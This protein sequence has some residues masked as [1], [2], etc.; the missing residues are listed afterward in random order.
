MVT[1]YDDVVDAGAAAKHSGDEESVLASL[2]PIPEVLNKPEELTPEEWTIIRQQWKRCLYRGIRSR[3]R[4]G[5]GSE[6]ASSRAS[7][8]R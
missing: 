7:R 2:G 3:S 8:N 6:A 1:A 5:M 4:A